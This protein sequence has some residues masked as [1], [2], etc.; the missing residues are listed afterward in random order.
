[1]NRLS[2]WLP[3]L[4]PM[5]ELTRQDIVEG[6]VNN[7]FQ[8]KGHFCMPHYMLSLLAWRNV[9][10]FAKKVIAFG[11]LWFSSPHFLPAWLSK[12][13]QKTPS[14]EEARSI[15]KCRFA[16]LALLKVNKSEAMY[17]RIFKPKPPA[18]WLSKNLQK[19]TIHK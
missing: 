11:N 17:G 13:I 2:F 15:E 9:Y 19:T 16:N 7:Q 4:T 18:A 3:A 5:K 14:L 8:I 10:F 1:M 6:E 12:N